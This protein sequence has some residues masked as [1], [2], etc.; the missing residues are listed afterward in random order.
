MTRSLSNFYKH[1]YVVAGS[2][3]RRVINTNE[4]IQE[5]MRQIAEQQVSQQRENFRLESENGGAVSDGE[6]APDFKE[7][8]FAEQIVM[9]EKS[10]QPS[11]EDIIAQ[12]NEEAQQIL[13]QAKQEAETILA[14]AR[15]EAQTMRDQARREGEKQGYADGQNQ[16]QQELAA[17]MDRISEEAERQQQEYNRSL[18]SMEPELLDTM[19]SIFDQVFRIQFSDKRELLLSLVMNAMRGIKETKQY[20]IR[21]SEA[22]VG[23]L[24]EQKQMLQEKVGED[25][26]IEIVMDPDLGENQC[27]ID[28]DSG[29]YDC[30][31]DVELDHLIRDLKSLAVLS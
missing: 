19:L 1:T 21:V 8:L 3:V 11:P 4:M 23:F 10:A 6:N 28:A 25:L 22:Q 16:A 12:A 18:E 27:M 31:L 29:V 20:K 7:G 15:Q 9:E 13:A 17:K 26:S 2:Q 30:S 5:R 14:N 24:R